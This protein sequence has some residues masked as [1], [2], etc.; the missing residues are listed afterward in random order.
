[1]SAPAGSVGI[2]RELGQEGLRSV[3]ISPSSRSTWY[4]RGTETP[5][6]RQISKEMVGR[7]TDLHKSLNGKQN[8]IENKSRKRDRDILCQRNEPCC[9]NL[10]SMHWSPDHGMA[11]ML[12]WFEASCM[13]KPTG[14]RAPEAVVTEEG[15]ELRERWRLV[16]LL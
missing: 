9:C 13:C 1:M 8:E 7:Q 15:L 6:E 2:P 11:A 5:R 16:A 12:I 4:L 10:M 3:D 14:C